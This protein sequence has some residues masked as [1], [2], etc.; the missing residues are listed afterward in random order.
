MK[1][2]MKGKKYQLLNV[3]Y[4]FESSLKNLEKKVTAKKIYLNYVKSHHNC[5]Q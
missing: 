5:N 2:L 4:L 3:K 1:E